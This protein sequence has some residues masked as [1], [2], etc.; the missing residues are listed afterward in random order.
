MA[1]VS[2]EI[3]NQLVSEELKEVPPGEVE[4]IERMIQ[5]VVG[6]EFWREVSSGHDARTEFAITAA[7]GTDYLTG[8]IDRLYRDREGLWNLIDFKTD[9]VGPELLEQRVK[10]YEFQVGFYAYL[11]HRLV[12]ASRVR[13]TVWFASWVARPFHSVLHGPDFGRIESEIEEIIARIRDKEF[14][15]PATPCPGCPFLPSGCPSRIH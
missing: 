13:A 4:A 11:L 9:A 7:F 5:G 15:P 14:Q 6:S 8:T 3:R 2:R 12:S 10:S 1:G